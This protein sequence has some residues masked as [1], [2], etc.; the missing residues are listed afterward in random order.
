VIYKIFILNLNHKIYDHY[1]II[2]WTDSEKE[3]RLRSPINCDI[4]PRPYKDDLS[5]PPRIGENEEDTPF[6]DPNQS[7]CHEM[8]YGE[9]YNDIK[10]L[11]GKDRI[12]ITLKNGITYKLEK[13][14]RYDLDT[15]ERIEY[16][17][18]VEHCDLL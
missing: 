17:T 16:L 15:G 1:K 6:L 4:A 8:V 11:I 13:H 5:D 10:E 14:E 12:Q 2:I 3:A 18:K 7:S 9:D